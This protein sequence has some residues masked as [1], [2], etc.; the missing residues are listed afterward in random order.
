MSWRT[1]LQEVIDEHKDPTNPAYNE[2]DKSPCAWCQNA[3][4]A[5]LDAAKEAAD[6]QALEECITDIDR[7]ARVQLHACTAEDL[8]KRFHFKW[9]SENSVEINLYNFCVSLAIYRSDCREWEEHHNGISYIV[10]RVRDTYMRPEIKKF[11]AQI[12]GASVELG[13]ALDSLK[14]ARDVLEDL[15]DLQNG[16]PLPKYESDWKQ[17]M[18]KANEIIRNHQTRRG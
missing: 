18:E 13:E 4:N 15:V 2:C 9:A 14:K 7:R 8:R 12:P 1:L 3:Q 10:E 5:I 11:V 6:A 17:T 16:S